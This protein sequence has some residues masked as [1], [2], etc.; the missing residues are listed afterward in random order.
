MWNIK[1]ILLYDQVCRHYRKIDATRPLKSLESYG[2]ML[3]RRFLGPTGILYKAFEVLMT[4]N[5]TGS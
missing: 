3:G 1:L 2:E 5:D 4:R